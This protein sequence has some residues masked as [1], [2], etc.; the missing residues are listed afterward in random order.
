MVNPEGT[1]NGDKWAALGQGHLA[2]SHYSHPL[3][4]YPEEVQNE[5]T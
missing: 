4:V 5:E 1:Q 2:V 3:M